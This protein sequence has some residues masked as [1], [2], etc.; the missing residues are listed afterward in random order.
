MPELPD[1]QAFSYNLTKIFKGKKLYKIEVIVSKKLNVPVKELQDALSGNEIEKFAREGKELHILFKGRHVL[2]L[3]LMLHGELVVFKDTDEPPKN[4]II[5]LVFYDGTNLALTDFQ[6]AATPTLDPKKTDVPDALDASSDYLA[7]K[8]SK[9]KTPVKTVVMDQKVIRGIGN[10]YADEILWDA[11]I[12]P[13]SAANKIPED[14]LKVLA[15]S[16]R[17]V[18]EAAEKQILKTKPGIISGEVR[19]FME[20][21]NHRKKQTSTGAAIHQKELASR[22]TYY[23]DEQELFS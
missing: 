16:I 19:D 20:V 4:Q 3:H 9:T 7:E 1:L 21:H 5:N 18:L 2:G 15:K 13:F 11:K 17:K 6:K 10:A 12:S 22:K 8:F 23:T 14:K